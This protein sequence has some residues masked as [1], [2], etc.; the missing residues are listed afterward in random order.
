MSDSYFVYLWFCNIFSLLMCIFFNISALLDWWAC[1]CI[2]YTCGTCITKSLYSS[3]S[4]ISTKVRVI[5]VW[6]SGLERVCSQYFFD[7]ELFLFSSGGKHLEYLPMNLLETNVLSRP[8][9]Y[10]FSCYL[11]MVM[12]IVSSSCCNYIFLHSP[13][14]WSDSS[15]SGSY[16]MMTSL[17][18]VQQFQFEITV[19][20]CV[21]TLP[22][23]FVCR[24]RLTWIPF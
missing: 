19:F 1:S 11:Q 13:P 23:D 7:W 20:C 3:T 6:G 17:K 14:S 16:R 5:S 15:Q 24:S 12:A 22:C 8:C 4:G 18:A 21:G 9:F 2:R 10:S